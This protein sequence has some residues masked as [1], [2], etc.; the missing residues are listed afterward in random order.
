[1]TNPA[2]GSKILL[3]LTYVLHLIRVQGNEPP[4]GVDCTG[5]LHPVTV[6][7]CSASAAH[8][9]PCTWLPASQETFHLI[10]SRFPLF[11]QTAGTC[12]TP[13]SLKQL[14]ILS[15]RI[16]RL[17]LSDACHSCRVPSTSHIHSYTAHSWYPCPC[18]RLPSVFSVWVYFQCLCPE[19]SHLR[20]PHGSQCHILTHDLPPS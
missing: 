11:I 14:L 19:P 16:Q 7:V 2:I 17:T 18:L 1:M 8:P 3:C 4:A 12:C 10:P 15:K 9:V 6:G 5:T 13:S 20:P